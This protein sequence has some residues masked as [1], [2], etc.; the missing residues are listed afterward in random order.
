MSGLARA[1]SERTKVAILGGGCG[2]LAAAWALSAPPALRERFEVTVYEPGWQLGGKG[3][4]AELPIAVPTAGWT[5]D[6]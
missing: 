3:Q 2:G 5:A 4:A 1:G 6:P